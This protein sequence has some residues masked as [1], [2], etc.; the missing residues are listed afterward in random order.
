[1]KNTHFPT[2]TEII[3]YINTTSGRIGKRDIARAFGI[4]GDD[5]T[6]LKHLLRDIINNGDVTYE[7]RIF[8][9]PKSIPSVIICEISELNEDGDYVLKPLSEEV[10]DRSNIQII[11][12]DGEAK[13]LKPNDKILARIKKTGAENGMTIYH[14]KFI[15]QV[16]KKP[17]TNLLGIFYE[18]EE[19]N[20]HSKNAKLGFIEPV[21]KKDHNQYRVS[22]IQ[23]GLHINDGDLVSFEANKTGSRH[24]KGVNI[25][26]HYGSPKGEKAL[27][28]IAIHAYDIPHIFPEEVIAEAQNCDEIANSAIAKNKREDLS[29]LPFVT[30][31][32]A[33]AKDHDDA[34]YAEPDLATDNLNGY[35]I[36]VAIADVSEYI[37]PFSNLD[38]EAFKR[39]NSVYFPDQVVPMLP[40]RI[41]NNL[42]SLKENE[43]RP[44]MVAVIRINEK[45]KKLGQRF[46][47]A[48]IKS[49][50]KLS[51]QQAQKAF[52][53][54]LDVATS[55]IFEQGLAPILAA[56]KCLCIARDKR[57]PLALDLPERK[58]ILNDAGLVKNVIVPA[59]LE[60]HKLVEE[61]MILANVAAAETLEK[62]KQPLIYRVHEQP[63][64]AK[65]EALNEF[66]K[67][68]N[69][70]IDQQDQLKPVMFNHILNGAKKSIQ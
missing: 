26:A 49:H 45:G 62:R 64:L 21:D 31:D 29:H 9:N 6:K 23:T 7:H 40:E 33:D 17:N 54:D 65:V 57:Q 56:Y 55:A 11:L 19:I 32:P 35:K 61:C 48:L 1:M 16:D 24:V 58:I 12:P 47:R 22:N 50:A 63:S 38:K 60:A 15:K 36:Y 69:I 43:L 2:K 52:D 20:S 53:G 4:K 28:L 70:N 30:I 8:K 5:R 27:S 10:K 37:K 44:A 42:C 66:L 13:S 51:Y 46:V 3:D 14:A 59:R 67:D 34:L 25:T 18:D 68:L 39:G 41:S